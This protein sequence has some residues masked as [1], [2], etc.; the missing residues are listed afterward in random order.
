MPKKDIGKTLLSGT[1]KQKLKL[2]AE[3]QARATFGGA[4]LLSESQIEELLG[5]F[6]KERQIQQYYEYER[7]RLAVVQSI[8]NLQ[9][10]A[11]EAKMHYSDLRG[12]ILLWNAIE[13]AELLVNSVLHEIKDPKE[14]ARIAQRAAKGVEML[15]CAIGPDKEGYL[16]IQLDHKT[17]RSREEIRASAD[18]RQYQLTLWE[19]MQN[20]KKQAEI[21]AT[22]YLSWERALL[23]FMQEKDFEP[24]TYKEL[25]TKVGSWVRSPII[26]WDKYYGHPQPGQTSPSQ[27]R[28]LNRYAVC[29]RIEDLKVNEAEYLWY[30][31][32]HLGD[33]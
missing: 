19:A 14:R 22:K 7:S 17:K 15:F 28:V 2:L 9:G 18:P 4:R 25:I 26:G 8:T 29:T 23:D 3:D 11:L 27:G 21:T 24:K 30:K 33:E 10:L 13:N 32:E 6:V 16:D 20:V 31:R 12:Y 1:T 5:S